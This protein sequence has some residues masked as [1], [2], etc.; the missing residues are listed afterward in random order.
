MGGT[1]RHRL[2]AH[3]SIGGG[4]ER[5]VDRARSI[6]AT[7]LQIFVKSARQWDA[8]PI[9]PDAAARFRRR[10][11][12]AGLE[13]RTMAHAS[14]LIN[15][16]S[17]E[18]AV[19]RRSLAALADELERCQAL[20]VPYLVLHPGSH[21]GRGVEDGL[22][23]LV[24]A[25]DHVLSR[26]R[27]SRG[28]AAPGPPPTILLENTAGQGATL[29]RRLEEL[30][31][32][33]DRCRFADRL[34]ICFDT[35]HALAAGYEFRDARSYRA[36]FDSIDRSVG[37]HRLCGFHL[38]DS[39]HPLGSRRDRHEHVGRGQVGLEAFRLLLNDP[40]FADVPM[41]LETPKGPDLAEDRVNLEVLRAMLPVARR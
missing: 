33:L 11:A 7:A 12:A 15:P 21:G 1:S 26:P 31:F 25:L 3:M 28:K 27:R 19:R 34:G 20:A 2:G 5:A 17:A 13:Q 32:V 22:L 41:V 38:N 8:R 24:D 40:R 29:G 9:D 16:A 30:A 18:P 6:D 4:F 10:A 37:L 35:C 39:K 36:T 23:S 14:Y